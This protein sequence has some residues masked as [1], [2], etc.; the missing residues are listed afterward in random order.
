[1]KA[2]TLTLLFGGLFLIGGSMAPPALAKPAGYCL[3]CHSKNFSF[4]GS[5]DYYSAA[6]IETRLVY[7]ARLNP[8]PGVKNLTEETFYTE[9]RLAQLSRRAAQSE[10]EGNSVAAWK[11]K[12]AE[13]GD[14]LTRLKMESGA[15]VSHFAKGASVLRSGL[16][17]A[18]AQVF[19]ARAESDRRWLIG[20]SGI[21]LVFVLILAAIGYRKL[22]RFGVKIIL[23]ALVCGAFSV[24]ACSQKVP[25]TPPKS[26]AQERLDQARAVA[27]KL[28]TKVENRFAASILLAETA[29]EWARIDGPESEKAFQLAWAMALQ[30][31]EEGKETASLKKV[32]DQ[33]PNPADALK[34]KVN[35]DTVLDLRDDLKALEGRTWA[36]RAVAE[37]WFQANPKKGREA[38]ESATREAQGIKNEDVRDIEFKALAEAWVSIDESRALEIIQGIRDPFLRS[39]SFV[40]A[41]STLK[42]KEKAGDLLQ[43]SWKRM[44]TAAIIPQKIQA[45]ARISAAAADLFPQQ[46]TDWAEKALRK[47]KELKD[48]LLQGFAFQEFVSAW[49][50]KDW[51]QAKKFAETIPADQPEGR[52]FAFIRIGSGGNIPPEKAASALRRAI[53]EAD[54]IPDSFQRQKAK[55]LALLKLA[56]HAPKE[57]GAYLPQISDPILR[58]EVETRLVGIRA[59]RDFDEALKSAAN[60][61]SEFLRSGAILK[62]LNQ[63]I[64]QDLAKAVPLFQDAMKSGSNIP[65]PY[66]R[67]LFLT[68]LGRSW[69]RIDPVREAALYEDALRVSREI[70]SPS[71]KAEVLEKLASAWKNTD[72]EKAQAALDAVD[73]GVLRFRAAAAEAK[74]WAKTDLVKAKH[75]AEAVPPT[76]PIEK[77]QAFKDLAVAIKKTEPALGIEFLQRAWGLAIA[78]PEGGS[79]EKILNQILSETTSLDVEKGLSLART[80]SDPEMKDRLLGEAGAGLFKE[81]SAASLT[82]ALKIAKEI[83]ESS[84]RA[85]V[86]QKAAERAAKGPIKGNEADPAILA[87]LSQWGR[88]KEAAKQEESEASPVFERA[89][90]EIGK[91]SA[92]RER[93]QI[94]SAMIG[95]WARVEER[96]ALKAVETI[97]SEMAEALSYSLLQLS[98]QFRKWSRKEAEAVFEKTLKAAENIPDPSL[99]RRRMV[100]IA[101]EWQ[102][103]NR[104][105]GKEVFGRAPDVFVSPYPRAK[106]LLNWANL[107]C[108]ESIDN[109]L[110]ILDKSLQFARENKNPR[111]LTEIALAWSWLDLNRAQ[112]ILGQIDSKEARVNGL[113]RLAGQRKKI[114][115]NISSSLLEKAK[116]E[117]MGIE[118]FG[119]KISALQ[120]VAMDQAGLD[121]V[122]AKATY[123]L[124]LRT[125]A[126]SEAAASGFPRQ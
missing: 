48:P 1:M 20:V 120:R 52:C 95:D 116:Q 112:E 12:T 56:V 13:I 97:P 57:A 67:V 28:T 100:Q 69:G 107:F 43:E 86:Y 53:G 109:D 75:A 101:R 66:A 61:P 89:F 106:S 8:C 73:P 84:L 35:F 51:D 70:S 4:K 41:A 24:S 42:D 17:K 83:S 81:E 5:S 85:A 117:S 45:F 32:A 46:K 33:W 26:V 9:S 21:I 79:K 55:K 71:L 49:A 76:F 11:R 39:V 108:K 92:P 36:L 15:S 94:L 122:K 19:E 29:K 115:P 93:A 14:S 88:A 119:E 50:R 74:L 10:A 98:V 25:E 77:A 123:D 103:I 54:R 96:M 40:G 126:Q 2:R 44:E 68:E 23:A 58:S 111:L 113:R 62:L 82:G 16:Q 64:P 104:E 60:I 114:Q 99:R 22:S 47:A 27:E 37:E 31:H 38:L 63:K 30:G 59:S 87:A 110:K 91:I 72:K 125:V 102:P 18:Y 121:R 90:A 80:I 7:Q 118:D 34:Q 105:K 6:E 124:I 78:M 65:D 3:E